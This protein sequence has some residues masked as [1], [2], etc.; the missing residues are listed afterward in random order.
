MYIAHDANKCRI[1]IDDANLSG[2]YYCPICDGSLFI[3]DGEYRRKHFAH[4]H[5]GARS[6]DGWASDMSD[7][8]REWQER[9]PEEC[10]EVVIDFN[11]ERHRADVLVKDVVVEFQHSRI[12]KEEFEKRN[13]FYTAA[14][15]QLIW[16][17]DLSEDNEDNE[18]IIPSAPYYYEW[19]YHW[20]NFN[21]YNV[22]ANKNITIW[23]QLKKDVLDK[24]GI[25][26]LAS[27]SR[28][29]KEFGIDD[30]LK[31]NL[32]EFIKY[33]N[34]FEKP[35]YFLCVEKDTPRN[36][37]EI[38]RTCESEIIV[39]RN[40]ITF[41]RFKIC[42]VSRKRAYMNSHPAAYIY[43]YMGYMGDSRFYDKE[44]PIYASNSTVWVVDWVLP[45]NK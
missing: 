28:D 27:L 41:K 18:Y 43:G 9:F 23:F 34:E 3:K 40:V 33:I 39:V 32:N 17:F 26:Q 45:D 8:H 13:K 16:L 22:S 36:L 29:C 37:Y 11:G 24:K 14:G 10:R 20:K 42:H 12:S 31:Y 4:K 44:L 1:R 21:E 30:T 5:G 25:V 6:C 2:D 19:K 35:N 15:Y 7:W 38:L